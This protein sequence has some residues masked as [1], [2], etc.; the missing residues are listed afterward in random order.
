MILRHFKK[1]C[2]KSRSVPSW[3]WTTLVFGCRN[4]KLPKMRLRPEECLLIKLDPRIGQTDPP[5]SDLD[6]QL[7]HHFSFISKGLR[8]RSTECE[9]KLRERKDIVATMAEAGIEQPT[10][11]A[12]CEKCGSNIARWTGTG[13]RKRATPKGTRFCSRKCREAA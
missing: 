11:R 3:Y 4:L 12:K 13:T 6:F 1:R 7:G 5:F 8:C 2:L 9:R 10:A